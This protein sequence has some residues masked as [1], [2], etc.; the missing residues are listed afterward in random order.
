LIADVTALAI[1]QV[2]LRPELAGLYHLAASGEVSWHGYASHVIG[3]AKANGEE[4]AVT[5][6]NPIDTTA[7]PTP[8]RRPLNSR[9]NTQKLRDNF[10]LHLPDWQSGVTRMLME[11][12]N[13]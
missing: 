7:Y 10:S 12:L 4:L 8:A 6:I 3:F 9:L 13:K 1:Q 11:V 5:T 2:Q